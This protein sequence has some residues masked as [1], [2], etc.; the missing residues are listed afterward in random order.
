MSSSR[1]AAEAAGSPG[2]FGSIST[3]PCRQFAALIKS[4]SEAQE[5]AL[6]RLE[7]LDVALLA[8]DPRELG[9][10][11]GGRDLDRLVGGHDPVA[12]ARQEVGDG[13]GHRHAITSST[14]SCRG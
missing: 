13:V 6:D 5:A 2:S 11:R 3:E 7:G 12:D 1:F 14:S 4:K 10:E 9:L 8:Q